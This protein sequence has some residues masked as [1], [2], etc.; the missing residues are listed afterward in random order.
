MAS[1]AFML[2]IIP[3]KEETDLQAFEGFAN[4]EEQQAFEAWHRSHGVQ[5][6]AVWHQNT[7][8]GRFAIVLLEADDIQAALGGAATSQE[9]FDQRFRELVKE[10]HGIDLA[11]DPPPEIVPVIDWRA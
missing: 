3:G 8:N 10:V 2:P 7:P 5:R 4:G 11:S 6:H 9:P 1:I